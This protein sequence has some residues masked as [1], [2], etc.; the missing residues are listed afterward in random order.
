M[1]LWPIYH[2]KSS[3]DKLRLL[4]N[5]VLRHY[6]DNQSPNEFELENE[7]NIEEN[8]LFYDYPLSK[9]CLDKVQ[10][11]TTKFHHFGK[12]IYMGFTEN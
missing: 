3:A 10:Y 11:M 7:Y 1:Q 4:P 6:F 12:H 8:K 9:Y 2:Y 5:G